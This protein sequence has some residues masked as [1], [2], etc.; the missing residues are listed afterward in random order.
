MNLEEKLE[1]RNE[2]CFLDPD[3]ET[4]NENTNFSIQ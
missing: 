1:E 2:I 3:L 4:K